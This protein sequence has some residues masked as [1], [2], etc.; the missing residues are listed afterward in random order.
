MDKSG[1]ITIPALTRKLLENTKHDKQN[2][3]GEIL[4][5]HLK[6]A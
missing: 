3:T 6:Q 2:L 5:I 1:C 4:E